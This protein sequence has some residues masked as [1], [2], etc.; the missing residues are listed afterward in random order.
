MSSYLFRAKGDREFSS[1]PVLF[2]STHTRDAKNLFYTYIQHWQ[3]IHTMPLNNFAVIL[4][5]WKMSQGEM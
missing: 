3:N 2:Q 5:V 1:E 4:A